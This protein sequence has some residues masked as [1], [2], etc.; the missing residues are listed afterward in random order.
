MLA[1]LPTALATNEGVAKSGRSTGLTCSTLQAI[2]A[3]VMVDYDSS[4]GATT[5]AFTA[6]FSNQVVINGGSFS[7]G[8]DSGSLVV[9]SDTARPVG[10]LYAGNTTNTTANPIQDVLKAF[11]NGAGT[12]TIVGGGD[13]PV[14][15][16][17]VSQPHIASLTTSKAP[18]P[19]EAVRV[20]PIR[21]KYASQ[22]FANSAVRDVNIGSSADN[23]Q[24]G[25]VVVTL[26]G[27]STIPPQ[28]DGVRTRVIYLNSPQPRATVADFNRATAS[29][30]AHAQTLMSQPG[31]QG[32]GVGVSDD[33]PAEPAM[34]IYTIAGI[35]HPAIPAMIDGLRTKI[36]EGDRF[37]AFGWGKET[38]PSACSPKQ[39]VSPTGAKVTEKLT[40]SITLP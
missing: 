16:S 27:A 12:A 26:Q 22:L 24:E 17:A 33:N 2:N 11:S 23:P 5:K 25:A 34:V 18:S 38:K 20:A 29:K 10:L 8:G 3:N 14:S 13:H 1:D 37:R 35:Q 40:E 7:A 9:T 21:D 6:T 36:V 28:L 31:I 30:E 32:V 39:R 15:C 19:Q 4:C